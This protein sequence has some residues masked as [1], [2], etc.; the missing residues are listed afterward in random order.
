MRQKFQ[1]CHVFDLQFIMSFKHFL[2]IKCTLRLINRLIHLSLIT[3]NKTLIYK[4]KYLKMTF[5]IPSKWNIS[6]TMDEWKMAV[7]RT[8]VYILPISIIFPFSQPFFL[9]QVWLIMHNESLSSS[10]IFYFIFPTIFLLLLSLSLSPQHLIWSCKSSFGLV[11]AKFQSPWLLQILFLFDLR[12][13]SKVNNYAKS[14][15]SL[16]VL[17]ISKLMTTPNSIL[18][19]SSHDFKN[20]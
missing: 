18:V 7:Y 12:N 3:K 20:R 16:L 15:I 11:I 8:F 14:S 9:L 17:K 1:F 19:W 2:Q 6:R 13:N 5:S 10:F 4:T